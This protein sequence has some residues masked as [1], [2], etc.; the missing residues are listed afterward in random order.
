MTKKTWVAVAAATLCTFP[1]L[2]Q[3]TRPDAGTLLEQPSQLPALPAPGGAATTRVPEAPAAAPITASVQMTPA[4][5]RIAG[6]TLFSEAELQPLLADFVGKQTNM[7]GLLKAAQAVRRYYRD[8][9]Y[10]LTE[11]YLPEQQ[12]AATGGTVLI[13][14]LEARV[15]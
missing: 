13:Q 14:V 3:Q 9:G 1:V 8:R 15:G 4:A 11:A 2:A 12:F 5:F 7:E 10:L 6:N